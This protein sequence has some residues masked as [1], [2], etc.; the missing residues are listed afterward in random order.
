MEV[1]DSKV[2]FNELGYGY[3]LCD[4]KWGM[5]NEIAP[6]HRFYYV[7][8][9]SG[10][11]KSNSFDFDFIPGNLYILPT[12]NNYT[13]SH[14][15][16]NPFEVIYYHVEVVPDI[17]EDIVR[18]PV[19]KNEPIFLLFEMLNY[20]SNEKDLDRVSKLV[21][22]MV[23]YIIEEHDLNFDYD[24]RLEK[25]L[26]YIEKNKLKKI[27]IE[28]L[29][30]VACME[31]SYFTR[32]FKKYY[33]VSPIQFVLQRKMAFA[34]REIIKGISVEYV[35]NNVGYSDSKA[36]SRAFKRIYKVSPSIY[37]KSHN[38]HPL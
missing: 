31:K 36:F 7:L 26:K 38:Q 25:V 5:K 17:V 32:F 18:I 14:N 4:R 15:P 27:R 29:A 21:S 34:S 19:N 2:V 16:D 28:Q 20:F 23:N 33:G 35:A 1:I 9:G 3:S 6:F 24:L 22:F 30:D 11:Y 37:R 12:F 13:L 10:H 8:S